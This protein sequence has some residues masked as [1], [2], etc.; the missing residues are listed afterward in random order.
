M[1]QTMRNLLLAL[2][3]VAGHAGADTAP[4]ST[5]SYEALLERLGTSHPEYRAMRAEADA[6]REA[7][8]AAAALPDPELRLE[9]MDIHDADLRPD[10]VGTTKY[11]IEQRLPLWGKRQLRRE[12][13]TSAHTAATARAA[14]TLAELRAQLR[15]AFSEYYAA[16]AELAINEATRTLF[17]RA[18]RSASERQANGLAPQQDLIRAQTEQSALLIEA[19]TLHG[20]ID[21]ARIA[22]NA[23]TG[24]PLDAPLAPP[25]TLPAS[26]DFDSSSERVMSSEAINAPAIEIV[27]QE[28]QQRR[29]EHRLADRERYPDLTVGI[30]PVQTGS[31]FETWELMLG[32]TLP[33]HGG[34]RARERTQQALYVAAEERQRATVLA[35]RTAAA[36]ARANYQA[37]RQ[38]EHLITTQLLPEVRLGYRSAL[39]G[40]GNAQLDFDAVV[41]AALQIRNAERQR[42]DAAVEQ[43]LAIA[44]FERRTGVQP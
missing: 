33:L 17:V 27:D 43:Q 3:L 15:I 34:A 14:Q 7:V 10:E 8:G 4:E 11:T 37:A 26:A 44:E 30:S 21:R 25:A 22:L 35:V 6:A 18:L 12:T 29:G 5:I 32:V 41:T 1:N 13:A 24:Q 28:L 16:S 9:L 40:Y 42:I 36:S 39:A 2:L 38:T 19:Q 23:L 31:R 20:R